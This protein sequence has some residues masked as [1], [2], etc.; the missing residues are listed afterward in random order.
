MT[1]NVDNISLLYI[2]I[3]IYM[4]FFLFELM[5]FFFYQKLNVRIFPNMILSGMEISTRVYQ[6]NYRTIPKMLTKL[7]EYR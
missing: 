2:Y 6:P 5:I 4:T 3:Y 1:L 7:P